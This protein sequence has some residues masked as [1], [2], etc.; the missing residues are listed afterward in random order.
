MQL[1]SEGYQLFV[2]NLEGLEYWTS[3]FLSGLPFLLT[4]WKP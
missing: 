4:I 3:N 1:K 2:E